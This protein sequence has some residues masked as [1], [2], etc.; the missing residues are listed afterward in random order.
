MIVLSILSF[1][2]ELL[3]GCFVSPII[4]SELKIGEIFY[5]S[6]DGHCEKI[7]DNYCLY[8]I[9][10]EETYLFE[11]SE[12]QASVVFDVTFCNDDSLIAKGHYIKGFYTSS[13]LVLCEEK[14]NDDLVYSIFDFNTKQ[15]Q[16]SLELSEVY[17]ILGLDSI[18]W[19][20]LC[21]TNKERIRRYQN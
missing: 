20:E 6:R 7:S 4:F 3:I 2:L 8:V 10:R 11:V 19:F 1:L 12:E 13:H 17:Q 15:I 21:S 5:S 14:S 16:N 9:R 18:Q